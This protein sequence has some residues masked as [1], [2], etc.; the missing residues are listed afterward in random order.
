M[1]G[2]LSRDQRAGDSRSLKLFV[3]P[4][5]LVIIGNS[6]MPGDFM[7]QM[8]N[9]KFF[10][11][12]ILAAGWFAVAGCG[13]NSAATTLETA[14]AQRGNLTQK[15][16]ATG[17]LSAVKSVDVGS[18][19][20]GTI[21]KLFVDFNSIVTN[22]QVVAQIDPAIYEANVHQTQGN[23]DNVKAARE[24]ARINEAREKTLLDGKL[25][26]QSDYDQAIASLHQADASVEIWAAALENSKANLNYCTI[27]SPIDGVVIARKLDV[28]QTVAASFNTPVLFTIANDLTKMNIDASI[29]ESDIGQ[30]KEGQTAEFTVDAFPDDV[31]QGKVVQVRKSPSTVNNV[32]TYDAIIAVDNPEQKLFPGMTADVS[33]LVAE[34]KNVLKI[35]NA[36][37]RFMPPD[38]VK[39]DNADDSSPTN[40][41]AA[42][43][44]T[45]PNQRTVYISSGTLKEPKLK[46]VRVK[47][48]VDDGADTEILDGLRE[49]DAVVTAALATG[50]KSPSQGPPR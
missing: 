27:L 43:L 5:K 37:L 23:L 8:F 47:I 35:P 39:V 6:K 15:I 10:S 32:V 34:R 29:S 14:A 19:I 25:V 21:L 49:G 38:G 41:T 40:Q 12:A 22:G 36:A 11:Q 33:I 30:V 4:Q 42:A 50:N 48:G 17:L 1:A 3:F 20:S 24:L 7:K 31:F 44:V 18:Q 2:I 28:G 45:A 46:I 16:T 26:S 9:L 13:K